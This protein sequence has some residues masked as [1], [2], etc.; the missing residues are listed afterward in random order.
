MESLKGSKENSRVNTPEKDRVDEVKQTVGAIVH[1]VLTTPEVK[2][3][4][5]PAARIVPASSDRRVVETRTIREPID[6]KPTVTVS[7]PQQS[8]VTRRIIS[9][10]QPI[11]TR[12]VE[13]R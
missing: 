3:T 9:S 7:T 1:P 6:L 11:T 5:E 4:V 12:T 13:V 8:E 10:G 2:R